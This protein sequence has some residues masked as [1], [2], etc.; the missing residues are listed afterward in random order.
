MGGVDILQKAVARHVYVNT[1]KNL[2]GRQDKFSQI[3]ALIIF[4]REMQIP[5]VILSHICKHIDNTE[6]PQD[7]NQEPVGINRRKH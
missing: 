1:A 5:V 7:R 2:G 3:N 6:K 4:P